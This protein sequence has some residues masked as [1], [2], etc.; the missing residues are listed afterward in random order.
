MPGAGLL[1]VLILFV[2]LETLHNIYVFSLD[3]ESVINRQ[4]YVA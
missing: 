1:L 2:V 3:N 4:G